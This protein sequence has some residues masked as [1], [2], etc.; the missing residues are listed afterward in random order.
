MTKPRTIR[1][2][3][4]SIFTST[5]LFSTSASAKLLVYEGFDYDRIQWTEGSDHSPEGIEG[6]DGGFGF[7]EP[8]QETEP[9]LTG[10]AAEARDFNDDD[11]LY[12]GART[13][14]LTYT[15]SQGRRLLSSPGQ[16]RD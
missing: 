8:W 6:L 16:V 9:H 15:D 4:V 2:A 3:A 10:I 13:E 14:P 12:A 1:L 5:I 7:A 11:G